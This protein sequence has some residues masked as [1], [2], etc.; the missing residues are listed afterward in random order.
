MLHNDFLFKKGFPLGLLEAL[1]IDYL[2][3][4]LPVLGVFDETEVFIFSIR[5]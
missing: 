1:K 5:Y 4:D 2:F 3:V